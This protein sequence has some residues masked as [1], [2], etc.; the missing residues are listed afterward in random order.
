MAAT[1]T[2][3]V[4]AFESEGRRLIQA[5]EIH[6]RIGAA[7]PQVLAQL[8]VPESALR[9]RHGPC[10]ACGGK[11]RFRFDNKR[12]RG[13]Y[14]CGQCGAGDGFRL[15]ER[16]HGWPFAEARKRVIEVA[17]LSEGATLIWAPPAP[18]AQLEKAVATPT[19]RVYRLRR[20]RCRIED[21]A[22]AV[23]YLASRGLWPL[24]EGCTL[25]AHASVEYFEDGK[26]VGRYPALVADVVD[27]ADE[28]VTVHV[29]HLQGGRKL[30]EREPRKIL[31]PMTG[32]EGCA[33]RLMP[34]REVLGVAE[35]IETALSAALLDD[36]PVW[37][38]LNTSLLAR[39]EP[40]AAVDT[41]R[42]YADRDEAGLAGALRL[43]ERL[44]GRVR[45]EVRIPT[46]PAKDWNDA[47]TTAGRRRGTKGNDV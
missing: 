1:S 17:G 28:L 4:G 34:P 43:L 13:D 8:G 29:T 23:D 47:L 42:L 41:V 40:P 38:A 20:G 16:V 11:D 21:C 9:N 6:A 19:E 39:F 18:R 30:T 22:D 45:L 14:I 35:G 32:R 15:L 7:W 25:S 33:V 44:Q 37:A 2:H 46:A 31:S 26:R 12:G 27:S 5:A 3:Q 24:P 36:V 10:P